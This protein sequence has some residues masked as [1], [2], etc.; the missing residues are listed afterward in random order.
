M[1]LIAKKTRGSKIRKAQAFLFHNSGGGQ[2]AIANIFIE[3][4]KK[5]SGG[6]L[7]AGD[8]APTEN[9]DAVQRASY[10]YSKKDKTEL[11]LLNIG[12]EV[13]KGEVRAYS[14]AG[15]LLNIFTFSIASG[16]VARIKLKKVS[17]EEHSGYVE[18]HHYDTNPNSR[19]LGRILSKSLIRDLIRDGSSDY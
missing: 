17:K 11:R 2:N 5:D 10:S 19:I 4:N 8:L 7:L 12:D 14:T 6:A 16:K 15:E 1:R 18:V 3:E 13:S 9:L